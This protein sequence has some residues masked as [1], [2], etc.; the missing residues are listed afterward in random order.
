MTIRKSQILL[1]ILL[2]LICFSIAITYYTKIVLKDYDIIYSEDGLPE[3]DE[4]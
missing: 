4:E 1:V 2:C 3:L